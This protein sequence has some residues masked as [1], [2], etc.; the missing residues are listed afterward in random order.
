MLKIKNKNLIPEQDKV[1]N[2]LKNKIE[3]LSIK[4]EQAQ[5]ML[6]HYQQ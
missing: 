3:E 4:L 5:K 1:I 6:K 2:D